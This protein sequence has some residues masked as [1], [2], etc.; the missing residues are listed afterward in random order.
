MEMEFGEKHIAREVVR[1]ADIAERITGLFSII[2]KVW[3][4]IQEKPFY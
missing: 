4:E 1:A 2:P 3:Q